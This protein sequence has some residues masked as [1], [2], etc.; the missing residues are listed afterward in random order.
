MSS[1]R[2][3]YDGRMAEAPAGGA[4]PGANNAQA[5][6]AKHAATTQA[7]SEADAATVARVEDAI[8]NSPMGWLQ[9][10][11]GEVDSRATAERGQVQGKIAESNDLVSKNQ[12]QAPADAGP[13]PA[14]GPAAHPAVSQPTV[15]AHAG[16]A[17]PAPATGGTP[18]QHAPV[19]GAPPA[20]AAA[21]A[22][23][24]APAPAPTIAAAVA[25]AGSD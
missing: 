13:P 6:I 22:A 20:K 14:H 3:P 23:A 16:P 18:A 7:G 10:M 12:A 21:P 1:L 11:L 5:L 2:F 15:A 24:P 8:K 25:S 17:T 4:G 19:A 9:S